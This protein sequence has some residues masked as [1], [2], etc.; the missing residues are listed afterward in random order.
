MKCLCRDKSPP[1]EIVCKSS[2]ICKKCYTKR[3]ERITDL[4]HVTNLE[5]YRIDLEH[6]KERP[7]TPRSYEKRP[8]RFYGSSTEH[9]RS[10]SESSFIDY[11][12]RH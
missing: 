3:Y 11:I 10:S 9:S 2:C 7:R 6:V 12:I 5:Q 4:L 1:R 8:C